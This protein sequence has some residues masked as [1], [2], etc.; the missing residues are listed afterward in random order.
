MN[1]DV[2]LGFHLQGRT[3]KQYEEEL[4]TEDSIG[5]CWKCLSFYCK[6]SVMDIP[7][8]CHMCNEELEIQPAYYKSVLQFLATGE[9]EYNA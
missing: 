4:F 8:R 6:T 2:Q 5:I 7:K 3:S 9:L 1:K